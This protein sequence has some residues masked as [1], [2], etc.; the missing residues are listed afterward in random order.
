MKERNFARACFARY[1]AL[2]LFV[3]FGATLL[4]ASCGGQEE[5][6]EGVTVRIAAMRGPTALGL[7]GLMDISEAGDALQDYEFTILGSPDEVPPLIVRGD[8]DVAAVPA[9]L[10]SVLYNQLN[11]DVV[12]L[13]IVTLGVLHVVDTS[14]EVHSIEDLR[15]RTVLV[16]GQGATP[17]FAFNY[18]LNQNGLVPGVDV[19]LDFRSEHAE[20]AALLG[21]GQGDV[22]LLPEPFVSTVLANIDGLRLALDLTEEWNRVQPEYGLIMS[23]VIARRQFLADS[24][25]AISTLLGEY[26]NSIDYVRGNTASAAQLAARFEIIPNAAIAENALPRTHVVFIDGQEMRQNLI[27]FY[28]VLHSENPMSVGGNLPGDDFFHS[29]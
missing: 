6:Q 11:G 19:F 14:G 20:V 25:G 13:A 26:K 9:N 1:A 7:L 28:G 22:A 16:H 24:P 15:G 8:I 12:A 4:M 17:E 18:V 29:R 21:T 5:E 23:V 27:G 10:A 3:V 2:A